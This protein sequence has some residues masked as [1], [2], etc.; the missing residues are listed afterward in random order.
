VHISQQ[1]GCI[2][3]C[4]L[5]GNG[6]AAYSAAFIFHLGPFIDPAFPAYNAERYQRRP[7]VKYRLFLCRDRAN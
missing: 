5:I 2:D 4:S 6:M 3:I 1:T 7:I